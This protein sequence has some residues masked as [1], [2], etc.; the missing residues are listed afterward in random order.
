MWS[1]SRHRFTHIESHSYFLLEIL[2]V[3]CSHCCCS[4]ISLH[5]LNFFFFLFLWCQEMRLLSSEKAFSATN[6]FPEACRDLHLDWDSQQFSLWDLTA[7]NFPSFA[8]PSCLITFTLHTD[9]YTLWL[10]PALKEK[11]NTFSLS[12]GCLQASVPCSYIVAKAA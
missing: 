11:T 2:V 1:L 10:A 8:S 7:S 12:N 4:C 5:Y 3:F 9:I 6:F